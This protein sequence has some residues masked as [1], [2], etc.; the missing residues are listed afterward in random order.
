MKSFSY[1][2]KTEQF[3]LIVATFSNNSKL[4]KSRGRLTFQTPS[5]THRNV[6]VKDKI[7]SISIALKLDVMK[8]T[9]LTRIPIVF[10]MFRSFIVKA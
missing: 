10:I 8:A 5:K 7:R 4:Q 6:N 9:F 3:K 1:R 2:E